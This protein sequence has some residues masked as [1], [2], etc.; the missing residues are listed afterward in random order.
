MI[1]NESGV[2]VRQLYPA[3]L[4]QCFV[5][6]GGVVLSTLLVL[7][8]VSHSR[9]E[10]LRVVCSTTLL[11]KVN[12]SYETCMQLSIRSSILNGCVPC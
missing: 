1:Q 5:F 10:G 6:L 2:G 7:C 8:L 3:V 9:L 12:A 11:W 4:F